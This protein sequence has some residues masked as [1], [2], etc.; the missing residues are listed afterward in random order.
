L[1]LLVFEL[2]TPGGFYVMFLGVSGLGVALVTALWPGFPLW[3][4]WLLFSILGAALVLFFRR[5]LLE[6][7]RH[8]WPGK[9]VDSLV[10]ET[11]TA[12]EDIPVNAFGKAEL[13][14]TSWNA[15]NSGDTPVVRA[16][17]CSVERMEGLTLYIRGQ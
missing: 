2:L 1:I 6:W 10:G 5:P 11:A 7:F 15:R 17:R 9:A 13:R 4:Q 12:M 16:Q 3:A 14:G 8:S